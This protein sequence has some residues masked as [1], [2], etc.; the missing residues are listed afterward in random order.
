MNQCLREI[1]TD[2]Y[3]TTNNLQCDV[4]LCC[5]I[6]TIAAKAYRPLVHKR[7]ELNRTPYMDVEQVIGEIEVYIVRDYINSTSKTTYHASSSAINHVSSR[8]E[9]CLCL[10]ESPSLGNHCLPRARVAITFQL[11]AEWNSIALYARNALL[12][13]SCDL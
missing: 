5:V 6:S 1:F 8:G 2:K 4:P 7:K 10:Y 13:L 12:L 11:A 3:S 9:P